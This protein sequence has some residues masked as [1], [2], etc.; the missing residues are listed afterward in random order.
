MRKSEGMAAGGRQMATGH[1]S[2]T[3]AREEAEGE[4]LLLP[5]TNSNYKLQQAAEDK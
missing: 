4:D 1:Q 2:Q 3:R 5:F